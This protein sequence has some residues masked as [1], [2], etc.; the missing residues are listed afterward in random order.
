MRMPAFF[1]ALCQPPRLSWAWRLG[2]C[3][4]LPLQLARAAPVVEV[5]IEGVEAELLRNVQT[6]LSIE[7]YKSNPI[8]T[9]DRIQRLHIKAEDEIRA[10]LQPFGYYRPRIEKSLEQ[11]GAESWRARY[12]ITPGAPLRIAAVEL[13]LEG[14]AMNDGQ[15][16]DLWRAFPLRQGDVLDQLQY[17][18]AKKN[19]LK[20]AA[21]RG[22]FDA[23]FSE[24]RIE[25]DLEAYQARILLHFDSGARYRFGEVRLHQEKLDDGFLRGYVPFRSGDPYSI[26]ALLE[27]Q[28]ALIDSDYFTR[29]EVQSAPQSGAAAVPVDVLLTPRPRNKYTLGVGYGTD[30]GAR[31]KLGW[32]MP[33]VNRLGHR[34]ESE[35]KLSEISDSLTARY[36]I[37]FRD[38][39]TEQLVFTTGVENTYTDTSESR[40]INA[41]GSL[42][43]VRGKWQQ[44]YSV[45][46]HQESFTVGEDTGISRLL[47][48]GFSLSR[49]WV[50]SQLL[51]DHGLRVLLEVRGATQ[52]L[53]SDVDFIQGRAYLK[54]VGTIAE[55]H[56]L[57][58]SMHAGTS[59]VS[60][61]QEL[62]ASVRFYAGGTQSVRGYR[63]QSLGPTDANG[64]VVGGRHLLTG[65]LEYDY[66][67]SQNW[68]AA[69]FFDIGNAMDDFNTP[70]KRG[71]GFGVRWMTPIGPLRFDLAWAVSE[72]DRPWRI[73]INVGP[74][75]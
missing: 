69:V 12:A 65:S 34:L 33:R 20:L 48:P 42:I 1:T 68:L 47:M 37:P 7:Q 25:V 30:T 16:Q 74:E 32:E 6:Q 21:E 22:Y 3:L 46:Y 9:E 64:E 4:L 41:G 19:V 5:Q 40:I 67:L 43:Q 26:N 59:S 36:R 61:F 38:P 73:H 49:A 60:E 51:I 24:H 39:R 29:V 57:I 31:G 63:Y 75:L 8:L 14:E 45:N 2:L 54:A 17:E 15:I 23:R 70:L 58:G 44:T 53:L 10:A 35:Y 56:R 66:R 71:A 13:Q 18:D 52:P 50:P 28:R 72:P 27:L 55:G 62:P 11:V